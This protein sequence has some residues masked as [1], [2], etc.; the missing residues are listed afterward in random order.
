MRHLLPAVGG[1]KSDVRFLLALLVCS[2][3]GNIFLASRLLKR[4]ASRNSQ[5]RATVAEF[6]EWFVKQPRKAIPSNSSKARVVIVEFSDYQCPACRRARDAYHPVIER[7]QA[8]N[9]GLIAW[10]IKDYPLESEC[11]VGVTQDLHPASCES[12]AAVR[13]AES[14]GKRKEL[15][16]LLFA[17]Q[18]SLTPESVWSMAGAVTGNPRIREGYEGALAAVRQDVALGEELQVRATPTI[19][20]NGVLLGTPPPAW[21]EA[22]VIDELQRGAP[23]APL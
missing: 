22:I 17:R 7:L 16:E 19:F 4:D 14:A 3:A 21:F 13:L 18:A 2:L 9:P 15:T 10:L 5:Q 1:T 6:K 20:V 12:A 23:S 8:E 11:N